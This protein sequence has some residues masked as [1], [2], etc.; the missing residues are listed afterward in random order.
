[1][2]QI[3]KISD[4]DATKRLREVDRDHV[5]LLA[6]S[7]LEIGLK[8]P[9]TV[10]PTPGEALPYRLVMGAHRLDAL[11]KVEWSELEIGKHVLVDEM[12]D[13]EARLAEIDENLARHELNA[14]DRAMFLKE[15]KRLYLILY[16]ETG[17]GKSKKNKGIEKGQSLPLFREAFGKQAAK[18]LNLSERLVKFAVQIADGLDEKAVKLIVGAKIARNQ[19]ELFALSCLSPEEQRVVA[20]AIH[21]GKAKTIQQ[22]KYAVGLEIK[23]PD[24]KQ[25]KVRDSLIKVWSEADKFT[26]AWFLEDYTVPKKA[27]ALPAMGEGK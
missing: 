11:K 3:I 4:I 7:I 6:A 2:A 1:M 5:E 19:R 20:A 13:D 18:K 22:A 21:D 24:D 27:D 25:R 15:R 9:I 12:S 8:Q 16:P 26:R 10:R 23:P 17:H 14:L